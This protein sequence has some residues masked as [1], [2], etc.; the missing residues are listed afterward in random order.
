MV[1]PGPEGTWCL[2]GARGRNTEETLAAGPPALQS[3]PQRDVSGSSPL[4]LLTPCQV[5]KRTCPA[6]KCVAR[7][8]VD[9][10]ACRALI[11]SAHRTLHHPASSHAPHSPSQSPPRIPP[12]ATASRLWY[13]VRAASANQS[14]FQ[15]LL[16]SIFNF[17]SSC[18]HATVSH[19]RFTSIS[20]TPIKLSNFS[21]ASNSHLHVFLCEVLNCLYY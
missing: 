7:S 8:S 17:R 4:K 21:S 5:S 6:L 14:T 3:C 16:L 2:S 13:F 19:C 9:V 18:G 1:F 10:H 15:Y 12:E 11:P 20:L